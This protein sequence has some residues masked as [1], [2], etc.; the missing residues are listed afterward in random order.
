MFMKSRIVT[1]CLALLAVAAPAFAQHYVDPVRGQSPEQQEQAEAR[2]FTWA[3]QQ[4]GFDPGKPW[5]ASQAPAP[6]STA[7]SSVIVRG[8]AATA[9]AGAMTRRDAAD[10]AVA[11][12][13]V[14]ASIRPA[15]STA[16]IAI[17]HRDV[18]AAVAG[19]NSA[20]PTQA[21]A[22]AA[23]AAI[24]GRDAGNVTAG[25][26]VAGATVRRD[27]AQGVAL[28]EQATPQQQ[29]AGEASFQKARAECLEARGYTVQ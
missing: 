9:A 16:T 18:G 21:A 14:L 4:S 25:G 2:C 20:P 3:M 12:A 8:S 5:F 29:L 17:K 11:G 1:R 24:L 10:A 28:Q 15:T 27:L 22:N 26:A 23:A 6:T 19:A 7:G 13:I